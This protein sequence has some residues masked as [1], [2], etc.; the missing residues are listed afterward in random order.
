MTR[1]RY[2]F[3]LPD[4]SHASPIIVQRD[5]SCNVMGGI[6]AIPWRYFGK[7]HRADRR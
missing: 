3:Q 2:E 6:A 5:G 4:D 7:H 1:L